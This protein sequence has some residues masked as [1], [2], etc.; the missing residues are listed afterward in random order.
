MLAERVLCGLGIELVS[1]QIVLA[2]DQ[3]KLFRWNNE[4]KKSLLLAYRTVASNTIQVGDDAKAHATTMASAFHYLLN[5]C[6]LQ[7]QFENPASSPHTRDFYACKR[8][9]H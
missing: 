1:C 8:R 5:R 6:S 3:L 7:C 2:A 4:M 9:L